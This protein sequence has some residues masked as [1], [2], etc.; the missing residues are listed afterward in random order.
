M[1]ESRTL[2]EVLESVGGAE[3]LHERM[4][5]FER[6]MRH[7]HD[8]EAEWTGQFP[9]R[10]VVVTEEGVIADTDLLEE[11]LELASKA[12]LASSEFTVQFLNPDPPTLLL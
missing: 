3:A 5:Q 8:H 4:D 12:N 9:N 6:V 2:D 7:F 10:W 1:Q 11:A